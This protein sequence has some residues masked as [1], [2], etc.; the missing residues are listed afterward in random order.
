MID[1]GAAR[2]RPSIAGE[3]AVRQAVPVRVDAPL[4]GVHPLGMAEHP[5]GDVHVDG[6]EERRLRRSWMWLV[7]AFAALGAVTALHLIV[8]D[9]RLSLLVLVLVVVVGVAGLFHRRVIADLEQ[10]RRGESES[11]QRILQGLSRSVSPAAIVEAI[12]EDLGVAATADHTVV[13]RLRADTRILEATL[14][15]TRAGVPSSTT[16]L[17]VTVLEDPGSGARNAPRRAPVAVSMERAPVAV[18]AAAPGIGEVPLRPRRDSKWSLNGWEFETRAAAGADADPLR[19]PTVGRAIDADPIAGP[20][21]ASQRIAEQ[22]ATRVRS[23]YG[24]KNTLSW[25]LVTELGVVGAIVLSRRT[26]DPWSPASKRLVRA[27]AEEASAA[28]ARAYSY[29]AAEARASTDALTGLPNRRYFDEFC[30]L[31][32]RRRRAEDA[33]GVLM[34]DIDHFKSLN[35]EFGHPAGDQVLRAVATAITGAVREGD[36]PARYGGEE[37]AVL[38]RNPGAE[39][40]LEV[41]E[42]V[43]AAVGALDLTAFGP[44][45]VT[46]SVGVAVARSVDQ[47]VTD[48]VVEA[49]H[50]LYRAKRLGRDRV[51]PAA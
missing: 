35:D 21:A 13:V 32:A 8:P 18:G 46:V 30:G 28:L 48:I 23:V 26:M 45:G 44:A 50:A 2:Q 24:L 33:V 29:R 37:F 12:V 19:L 22:L 5:P 1:R 17:P 34:I 11:F 9:G 6:V 15:S 4:A 43:R 7:A 25:A 42:R 31:L 20:A 41:G 47:P 27:A 14:V 16:M 38:L 36:V 49:D 10:A 51:V 3:R 40:A 39:V